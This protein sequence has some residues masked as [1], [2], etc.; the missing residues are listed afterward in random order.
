MSK[1][2][3]ISLIGLLIA[4]LSFLGLPY[5]FKQWSIFV[6]GLSV[7]A[8]GLW[9]RHELGSD[10]TEHATEIGN[11]V[12]REAGFENAKESEHKGE[13][14]EDIPENHNFEDV[15]KESDPQ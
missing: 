6:L 8:L 2:T 4:L 5:V 12:Y 1:Y 7:L 11:E 9:I 13:K 14:K 10:R 15:S 3:T